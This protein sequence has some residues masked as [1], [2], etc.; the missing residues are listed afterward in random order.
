M[1][2][3]SAI[4]RICTRTTAM[5]FM[6]GLSCNAS[7]YEW[8]RYERFGNVPFYRGSPM[9]V[10]KRGQ[11]LSGM[12][13]VRLVGNGW[14]KPSLSEKE[15]AG[16]ATFIINGWDGQMPPISGVRDERYFLISINP[17]VVIIAP[18]IFKLQYK[19]KDQVRNLAEKVTSEVYNPMWEQ[20]QAQQHA[21]R[22]QGLAEGLLV[23]IPNP[24]YVEVGCA[25]P[26]LSDSTLLAPALAKGAIP[27]DAAARDKLGK[28]LGLNIRKHPRIA[29]YWQLEKCPV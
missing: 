6:L 7:A 15:L 13:K 2:P 24:N 20:L 10:Q 5:I 18:F 29:A 23:E 9:V 3:K 26:D 4:S 17:D 19:T 16:R 27:F 14:L 1:S 8:E 12:P 25:F 21:A 28:K 22:S 11:F